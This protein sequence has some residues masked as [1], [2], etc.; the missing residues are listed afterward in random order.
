MN[1]IG[2]RI[3]TVVFV[4]TFLVSY[5]FNVNAY[6]ETARTREEALTWVRSQEGKFLDFDGRYGEQC[7][8]F[9]SFYYQYLGKPILWGNANAFT[10]SNPP[11]GWTKYPTTG[12]FVPQPGDVAATT[13]GP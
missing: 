12:N 9:L 7:V 3:V 10:W 4:F 5:I 2:K 11:A 8:D 13:A 6:A 1:K